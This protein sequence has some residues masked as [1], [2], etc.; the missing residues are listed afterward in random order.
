MN[1]I[2]IKFAEK[3]GISRYGEPVKFGVPIPRGKIHNAEEFTLE[4]EVRVKVDDFHVTST[5]TWSDGSVKWVLLEFFV[6]VEA[7]QERCYV[8]SYSDNTRSENLPHNAH[9]SESLAVS[10][11]TEYGLDIDLNEGCIRVVSPKLK[12]TSYKL[13]SIFADDKGI[14]RNVKI[15][16]SNL[17]SSSNSIRRTMLIDAE[18]SLSERKTINVS[19][20]LHSY[21]NSEKLKIELCLHN[22]WSAK[23]YGG[24]WDLGDDGSLF[25][26]KFSV[27]LQ[28]EN[29]SIHAVTVKENELDEPVHSSASASIG[30]QVYI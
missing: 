7:L 18:V 26:K 12:S 30:N 8:L 6:T 25:F 3:H 28:P 17:C 16:R 1:R 15:L 24:L 9:L 22:P 27:R 2:Q 29:G 21:K 19:F 14:D 13:H 20:K 5:A 23:H 10:N 11:K 4:D